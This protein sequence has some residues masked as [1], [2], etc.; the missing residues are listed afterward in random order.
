MNKAWRVSFPVW[1]KKN[2]LTAVAAKGIHFHSYE[3]A[4][5]DD[6]CVCLWSKSGSSD[7]VWQQTVAHVCP[8]RPL[9][10]LIKRTG[11]RLWRNEWTEKA[12]HVECMGHMTDACEIVVGKHQMMRSLE[13]PRVG[14]G[15]W[16][17]TNSL[18][19]TRSVGVQQK[20]WRLCAVIASRFLVLKL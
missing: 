1:N 6:G 3:H 7:H 13:R 2:P 20:L 8:P 9:H 19:L 16:G 5:V 10:C 17:W 18:K 15:G 12:G 11:I 14:I 4:G